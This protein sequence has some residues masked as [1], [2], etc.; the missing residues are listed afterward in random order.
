MALVHEIEKLTRK[1]F[2]FSIF[3]NESIE[4]NYRKGFL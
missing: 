1:D 2:K 4:L 3:T